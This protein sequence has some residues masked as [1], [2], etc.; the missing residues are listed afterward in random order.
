M[1]QNRKLRQEV[2]RLRKVEE[3]YHK[4]IADR[5]R[6]SEEASRNMLKVAL[7][8]IATGKNDLELAKELVEH[9]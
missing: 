3:E 4:S 9:M 7:V 5:C 8:G 2:V 1:A 6:A